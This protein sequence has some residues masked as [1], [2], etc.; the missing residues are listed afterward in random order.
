MRVVGILIGGCLGL[1]LCLLVDHLFDFPLLDS[2]IA[3][4][5]ATRFEKPDQSSAFQNDQTSLIE[6]P[7]LRRQ[8]LVETLD[9]MSVE[10]IKELLDEVRET[11]VDWQS[12]LVQELALGEL[13]RRDPHI[14]LEQVWRAKRFRWRELVGQVLGEWSVQNLE[15]AIAIAKSLD[16]PLKHSAI[17]GILSRRDDLEDDQRMNLAASHGFGTL[18]KL[19]ISEERAVRLSHQP[20]VALQSLLDDEIDDDAQASLL[21]ELAL[22]WVYQEGAD[23]YVPLFQALYDTQSYSLQLLH[24]ITQQ[25]VQNNPREVWE[26]L[27]KLPSNMRSNLYW[28]VLKTWTALDPKDAR[29]AISET[30]DPRAQTEQFRTLFNFW[31]KSRPRDLLDNLQLVPEMHRSNSIAWAIRELAKHDPP[32]EAIDQLGRLATQEENVAYASQLL[33]EAWA[34]TDPI[35]AVRWILDEDRNIDVDHLKLLTIALPLL[36][37]ANPV[38]AIEMLRSPT[39]QDHPEVDAKA[40]PQLGVEVISTLSLK[41]KFDSALEVLK[42]VESSRKFDALQRLGLRLIEFN[43]PD[44]AIELA[45]DLPESSR[46]SYFRSLANYWVL[47]NAGQLVDSIHRLPSDTA[48]RSMATVVWNNRE[49][50]NL[51]DEQ[52]AYVKGLLQPNETE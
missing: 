15:E 48:R 38:K 51:T 31:A 18:A 41:G 47:L 16:G 37:D 44:K 33:V 9:N 20:Q 34:R 46:D 45:R 19:V 7:S 21:A 17:T 11:T 10:R 43:Q 1:G 39:L 4:P 22:N 29:D 5:A 40:I 28:P 36:A 14:A 30:T 26:E 35:E 42:V 24:A 50:V 8:R 49:H 6:S 32:K 52:N 25:L 27:T 13:A 12:Q 3:E 2:S 23:A